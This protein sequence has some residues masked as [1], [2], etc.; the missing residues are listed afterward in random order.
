M[1]KKIKR[2][3]ILRLLLENKNLIFTVVFIK[4]NGEIRRMKCQLGVKKHLKGGKLSFNPEEKCL[5]IVFDTEKRAYRSI[6]LETLVS[7]NM[8]GEQY[9]VSE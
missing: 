1:K 3:E 5:L 2:E 7:I 9:Y 8:K 4:K 6:T